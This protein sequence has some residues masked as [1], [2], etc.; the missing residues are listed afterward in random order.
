MPEYGIKIYEDSD[1][2]NV[3][4]NSTDLSKWM[5]AFGFENKCTISRAPSIIGN[6]NDMY[7]AIGSQVTDR[8]VHFLVGS[9]PGLVDINMVYGDWILDTT[10]LGDHWCISAWIYAPLAHTLGTRYIDLRITE[11]SSDFG[12]LAYSYSP[13]LLSSAGNWIR[14]QHTYT[15]SNP[16][17]RFLTMFI[18]IESNYSAFSVFMQGLQLERVPTANSTATAFR[19]KPYV[20]ASTEFLGGRIFLGMMNS[21]NEMTKTFTDVISDPTDTTSYGLLI[22]HVNPGGAKLPKYQIEVTNTYSSAVGG[23]C[24]TVT[25]NRPVGTRTDPT[26][27]AVFGKKFRDPDYG[28]SVENYQQEK[29]VST[30]YPVPV[31]VGK[32]TFSG[33]P[34]ISVE[35]CRG[36]QAE[37]YL[38]SAGANKLILFNLPTAAANVWYAT[39]T[40]F[41]VA[42]PTSNLVKAEIY[43]IEE[44][45]EALSTAILPEA[46]VFQL[47]NIG[48]L[49]T[50]H[51]YGLQLYDAGGTKTFD[52]GFKHINIKKSRYIDF[53]FVNTETYVE[54]ATQTT[55]NSYPN[56]L[57]GS[58]VGSLVL[59]SNKI[60][61][62]YYFVDS[63]SRWYEMYTTAVRRTETD[64]LETKY[65][66]ITARSEARFTLGG[67][68]IRGDLFNG[69]KDLLLVV[70]GSNIINTE[71]TA[72]TT[73]LYATI[74][75]GNLF[76][77]CTYNSG[78]ASACA[79]VGIYTANVVNNDNSPVTYSWSLVATN[80]NY[81]S[82]QSA[83]NQ[84]SV[85][86][87][88]Y[89]PAGTYNNTLICE[90]TAPG[91]GSYTVS[92]QVTSTHTAYD[93]TP[94]TVTISSTTQNIQHNNTAT[95]TFTFS[96]RVTDF[97]LDDITATGSG[98]SDAPK[99]T[100]TNLTTTDN[101][102]YTAYYTPPN[103]DQAIN[104]V[105]SAGKFKDIAGNVN[106]AASNTY[107]IVVSGNPRPI[108]TI[109][110]SATTVNAVPATITFN[111]SKPITSDQEIFTLSDI[112]ITGVGT[113]SN[114]TRGSSTQYTAIFTPPATGINGTTV[115]IGVGA[116]TFADL[117]NNSNTAAASLTLTLGGYFSSRSLSITNSDGTAIP[118]IGGYQTLT[119]GTDYKFLFTAKN[120]SGTSVVLV[121]NNQSS[122]LDPIEGNL[123]VQFGFGGYGR[124]II[125]INS[126]DYT[127]SNITITI[128]T[129]SVSEGI[130]Y[131]SVDV[132]DSPNESTI[133]TSTPTYRISSTTVAITLTPSFTISA[134]R[135][136]MDG[137]DVYARLTFTLSG[138]PPNGVVAYRL[139]SANPNIFA[140]SE[141]TIQPSRT[142]NSNGEYSTTNGPIDT[143]GDPF[144]SSTYTW[145]FTFPPAPAGY[146]YSTYG[147]GES[148]QVQ[149]LE[150]Q[151]HPFPVFKISPSTLT[152]GIGEVV[153]SVKGGYPSTSV[154]VERK[155]PGETDFSSNPGGPITLDAS[156]KWSQAYGTDTTTRWINPG[157]YT[158]RLTFP[159]LT[160]YKYSNW[161]TTGEAGTG[162][163]TVT[164]QATLT[165][166]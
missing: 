57:A 156:G 29:L 134:T 103:V 61:D 87:R 159:Q 144:I 129:S 133:F 20:N 116:G 154:A 140:P 125:P 150:A 113:L 161:T 120:A 28:I 51:N 82:F 165:V 106:T 101:I 71:P 74:S 62:K 151:L 92:K 30:K 64:T 118:T 46:Y 108:V 34:F 31:Y 58:R 110:T 49:Q 76:G 155:F 130:E 132:K 115:T 68:I 139:K 153:L 67:Y 69:S 79:T 32:L 14:V 164:L 91:K 149:V 137:P 142:L 78:T 56:L 22:H 89:A 10:A 6:P 40:N 81:F 163:N 162:V 122:S 38:G 77:E 44:G 1:S 147:N 109:S 90:V 4:P 100:F 146:V 96:E 127:N 124:Q 160:G 143:N 50:T 123:D 63:A 23:Y 60:I 107:T 5:P 131:F 135:S 27:I 42:N 157:S 53:T 35:R 93:A 16:N 13:K 97:T 136:I 59:I 41:I 148:R 43:T 102:T 37:D 24:P 72:T 111:F 9:Y 117:G 18:Q 19:R 15:I 2:P 75:I 94:P 45:T 95:F 66:K 88:C 47:D 48:A 54:G 98:F 36:W 83:T 65:A 145:E 99:G 128:P 7:A 12:M 84:Q 85:N 112:T 166:T 25:F 8:P 55:V 86:V 26:V 104:F 114:L 105:I 141:W 138:G 21:N 152:N 158:Y 70:D 73:S 52:S 121:L 39:I 119:P 80:P 33:E 17:T 11:S 126:N 3:I